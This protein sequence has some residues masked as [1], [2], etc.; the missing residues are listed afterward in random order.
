MEE[1]LHNKFFF[2]YDFLND[3]FVDLALLFYEDPFGFDLNKAKAEAEAR[4]NGQDVENSASPPNNSDV[5]TGPAPFTVTLPNAELNTRVE[6]SF[7]L[8]PNLKGKDIDVLKQQAYCLV[9]Q[10]DE[11]KN[12]LHLAGAN[13]NFELC[14]YIIE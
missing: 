8:N 13:G 11:G 6:E 1:V 7:R 4:E 2:F 12:V 9:Q 14:K 3:G 5:V 10:N